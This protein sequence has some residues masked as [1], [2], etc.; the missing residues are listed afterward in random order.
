MFDYLKGKKLFAKEGFALFAQIRKS[1]Y[2]K[3]S[4]MY[5]P[6]KIFRKI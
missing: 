3:K 1:F 2:R 5:Q 4:V 6:Q